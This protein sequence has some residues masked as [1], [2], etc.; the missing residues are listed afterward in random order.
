MLQYLPEIRLAWKAELSLSY[1]SIAGRTIVADRRHEGPLVV[2]R[3]LYPEGQAV[4]HSVLVH[5]P[6]GIAGGD[7]LTLDLKLDDGARVLLTTPSATKWYKSAG[8]I[9]RQSNRFSVGRSAVLEWLPQESIVFDEADAALETAIQL[10]G[11]AVYAGWE[12]VCL[13]RR[14]S[15]ESFRKGALLQTLEVRRAGRLI[16]NDRIALAGGDPILLSPVGL[17]GRH[18][19]G[20]MV[21]AAPS[22]LPPDL[23]DACR[24]LPV[25]G[26]EA[27]ITVLPNVVSARYLGDSAEHAKNYFESLRC[28]LRPWYAALHAERPRIWYS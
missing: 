26:G 19:A 3:P 7:S 11:E 1:Q 8:R 27:G 14:A 28:V 20:A 2:Q 4:C 22:P 17:N 23:L 18:V 6:G 13:G 25:D 9:A 15:G 16:W 21:V 12:I 10:G 5:P 24:S